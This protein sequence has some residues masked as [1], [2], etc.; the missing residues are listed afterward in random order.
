VLL[1]ARNGTAAFYE[2]IA[3][4]RDAD[5]HERDSIFRIPPGRSALNDLVRFSAYLCISEALLDMKILLGD[6]HGKNGA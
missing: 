3:G 1:I 5:T 6:E 4:P 2:P